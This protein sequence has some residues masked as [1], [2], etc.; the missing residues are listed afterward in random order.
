MVTLNFQVRDG[1]N[2][3]VVIGSDYQT[4]YSNNVHAEY[5]GRIEVNLLA[6]K[7]YN[8]LVTA[9]NGGIYN[10]DYTRVYMKQVSGNLS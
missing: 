4:S 10:S 2:S 8:V 9:S 7:S 1:S 5:N 3:N 6:G